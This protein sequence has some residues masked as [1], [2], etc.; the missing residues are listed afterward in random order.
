[1]LERAD[2][3]SLSTPGFFSSRTALMRLKDSSP[4]RSRGP[5]NRLL[6]LFFPGPLRL[7][8]PAG[9]VK[10]PADVESPA[11][12]LVVLCRPAFDLCVCIWLV[13]LVTLKLEASLSLSGPR[14]S[15]S[16]KFSS[17][18]ISPIEI[19]GPPAP[20]FRYGSMEQQFGFD[21][22]QPRFDRGTLVT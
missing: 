3:L 21:R 22:S 5:S 12:E 17:V 4:Q 13:Y 11:I 7:F 2:S 6:F 1:M 20:I 19:P 16:A 8:G 14:V 15:S 9:P 18:D 10:A